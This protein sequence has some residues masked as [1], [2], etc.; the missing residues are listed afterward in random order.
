[1]ALPVEA[2]QATDPNVS[3]R[4]VYANS[5]SL[6]RALGAL[7]THGLVNTTEYL[8]IETEAFQDFK[9]ALG[10][11]LA[12]DPQY[13]E[14]LFFN[15]MREFDVVNGQTVDATG[16]PVGSL[17]KDGW[18]KS[19][20]AAKDNKE[21]AVQAERDEGD[22]IVAHIVDK[23]DPGE[24][25]AV[26][27][28]EPKQELERNPKFWQEEMHYRKGLAVAQVYYKTNSGTVLAG[29]Y[30]IKN[31]DLQAGRQ[32]LA[33]EGVHVPEGESANR[34]IR[35]GI[36]KT[37]DEETARDYGINLIKRH[38]DIVGE[39]APG[40]SVTQFINTNEDFIKAYFDTYVK[41]LG[42]AVHSGSNNPVLQNFAQSIQETIGDRLA[43]SDRIL[44]IKIANGHSFSNEDGR[45]MENCIRYG[46]VEMLRARLPI[47]KV[48][49][50][51]ITVNMAI[52][53]TPILR[54]IDYGSVEAMNA[55]I[56]NAIAN[57]VREKRTYGGCSGSGLSAARDDLNETLGQQNI[58]AG[59][60]DDKDPGEKKESWAWKRGTCRIEKCPTRPSETEIGPCDVCRNC[61]N[62]FDKGRDPAKL[63]QGLK[64]A[65]SRAIS[66]TSKK[67][68]IKVKK[69]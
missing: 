11:N 7:A 5:L 19:R 49:T 21:M 64:K 4:E 22:M 3:A 62:W 1:M 54:S 65:G 44:L 34:M 6:L 16:R 50:G 9:T 25:Y 14:H 28:F 18:L 52:D 56:T 59:K 68:K 10:E 63:Y 57:G 33:E 15:G 45:F 60:I 40:F 2:Q 20:E 43:A 67:A 38:A 39:R 37:T 69:K 31:S 42:Q 58:F 55:Q 61:Q 29:A 17:V 24:M 30:S 23:L 51:D 46:L 32:I 53:H 48:Q 8:S 26:F 36:R 12:T 47:D 13:G 66:L 35:Y 27:S 41:S